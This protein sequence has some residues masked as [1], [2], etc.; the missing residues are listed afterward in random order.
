MKKLSN[1]A[2][3]IFLLPIKFDTL[4]IRFGGEIGIKSE[5]T[6]RSYENLILKN[7]K[8]TLTFYN[9]K[10]K[11]FLRHPGR[12]YIKMEKPL[13]ASEKLV[14]VFGISSLSPAIE[15]TSDL[16]A[17]KK[18]SLELAK[19]KLGENSKFAVRCRR[20]GSHPYT[21][22]DVCREIGQ[23]ILDGLADRKL[24]VDLENPDAE[25]QIEI[26]E[27]KAY[28]YSE[29]FYGPGG[30]PLGAQPKLVCLLSGGIDSPVACWL[31]MKRGAPIIPI[32]FD[33]YPF[34]DETTLKRAVAVAE[35]LAEWA[36]GYPMKF[37]IIPHGPNLI[38]IKEK[39]PERL[40]CI[41]CKR[42][43]YRI[44]EEVARKEKAEGIVTG[45][46]I[47]EQASQTLWNLKVL[48]EAAKMYPVY[49]PLIGF[50]K[51]ETERLSKKI[52]TFE[53][54][55]RK[56]MGCTAVPKRPATRVKLKNILEVEKTLDIDG[57][58]RRSI[59]EAKILT[60]SKK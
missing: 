36:I 5:W 29:V 51:V 30:F 59:R 19:E 39:G 3:G 13:A 50:D 48:N 2:L 21:S 54:S 56:A 27:D 16:G 6:R 28:I 57:M 52:G 55:T 46:S 44:A 42:M 10:P 14:K 1:L 33:N 22:M 49:R 37:Y 4:I 8:K 35:K 58:I 25:I 9:I 17:I 45:E 7:I 53:V 24:K 47:G 18:R 43:M 26:R 11:E 12:I 15:T 32:Y 34:T 31:V 23:A 38:E 20:V 41:L 60:L 40:T